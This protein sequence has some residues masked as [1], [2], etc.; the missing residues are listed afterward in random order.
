LLYD[1]FVQHSRS[2]SVM[3]QVVKRSAVAA[4]VLV[5]SL[6]LA[7]CAATR[8]RRGIPDPSGF[9]GDYSQLEA[10]DDYPA[11][12]V[13]IAPDA[14][15]SS[16]DAVNLDSVTLWKSEE[17]GKLSDEERQ[18]LTDTLFTKLHEQLS[19]Y[20]QMSTTPGPTTVRVRAALTQAK[21]AKVVIRSVTTI[22]PQLRLLGTI[23]GLSADTAT[24]VGSAT[25]EVEILD[26]VTNRRLAAA[27]D[28]RAGT[29]VIF[30]KR[31]YKTWG[32]VDAACE[33]W[34]KRIAWQLAKHGVQLKEGV[35]MP[36]EPSESR[37][38]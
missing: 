13:Y 27:V 17:T 28:A 12:E 32:D 3:K 23:V 18:M 6:A 8:G 38:F 4:L 25:V 22:I 26:S 37:S 24:M 16:F 5:V 15:W 35:E 34:A 30:A 31:S 7:G 1:P 21:G 2:E 9:L 20:F 33:Y 29:K 10:N 11:A 36:E 19:Q 14:D